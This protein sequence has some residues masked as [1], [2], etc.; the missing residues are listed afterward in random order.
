MQKEKKIRRARMGDSAIVLRLLNDFHREGRFAFPFDAVRV[1]H[2]VS[3]MIYNDNNVI[4]LAETEDE[5]VG[6]IGG[7]VVDNF[8]TPYRTCNEQYLWI[9]PKHRDGYVHRVLLGALEAWAYAQKC[10]MMHM[11]VQKQIKLAATS[12]LYR[13][14]GFVE[15]PEVS[16]VKE[17]KV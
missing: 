12:R 17:L 4:Y 10:N 3:H 7:S 16:Y 2:H 8:L 1:S 9:D 15:G 5:Y 11:T 14:L 6:L 13:M